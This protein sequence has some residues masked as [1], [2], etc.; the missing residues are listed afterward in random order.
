MQKFSYTQSQDPGN[1]APPKLLFKSARHSGITVSLDTDDST[2]LHNVITS[3]LGEKTTQLKPSEIA[4]AMSSLQENCEYLRKY[5]HYK[6]L[7]LPERPLQIL[8]KVASLGASVAN[9]PQYTEFH[10]ITSSVFAGI[11]TKERETVADF[12]Y[13]CTAVNGIP[14][15]RH[16]CRPECAGNLPYPG[17]TKDSFCDNHVGIYSKGKLSITFSPPAGSNTIRI[18]HTDQVFNLSADELKNLKSKGI[19]KAALILTEGK[20]QIKVVSVEDISSLLGNNKP[21]NV[22]LLGNVDNANSSKSSTSSSNKNSNSNSTKSSISNSNKSSNS[23]SNKNS[24]SGSNKSTGSNQSKSVNKP[25]SNNGG[26]NKC[27]TGSKKNTNDETWNAGYLIIA[28]IV[29]IIIIIII[30]AIVRCFCGGSDMGYQ[31][32]NPAFQ[33]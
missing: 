20:K 28:I 14:G 8:M 16:G 27:S 23:A 32:T 13:G 17:Y 18:Y 4:T 6:K 11:T 33:G 1:Q 25:Q 24:N 31:Y 7:E 26:S 3:Q 15:C 10:R 19:E 22:K 12:F 29:I 2:S 21:Q 5:A 30:W 9:T